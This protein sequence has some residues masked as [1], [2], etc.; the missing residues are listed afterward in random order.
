MRSLAMHVKPKQKP[1][2]HILGTLEQYQEIRILG[3]G[4]AGCVSLV[5]D[6]Y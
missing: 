6:N 1:A 4:A 5:R 2:S 3:K